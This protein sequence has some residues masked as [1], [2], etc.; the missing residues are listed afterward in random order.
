MDELQCIDGSC[1]YGG[2]SQP[3][4]FSQAMCDQIEAAISDD[5]RINGG[6]GTPYP[7]YSCGAT[8]QPVTDGKGGTWW[9]TATCVKN[10]AV[11]PQR[12]ALIADLTSVTVV[13]DRPKWTVK[14]QPSSPGTCPGGF[15]PCSDKVVGGDCQCCPPTPSGGPGAF[16]P[17]QDTS[18]CHCACGGGC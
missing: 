5:W 17:G 2:P 7:K 4:W 11:S 18:T 13:I 3:T 6:P 16:C 15:P 1:G 9:P 10:K 12:V 8:D 14:P